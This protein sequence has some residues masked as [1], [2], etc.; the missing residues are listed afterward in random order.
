MLSASRHLRRYLVLLLAPLLL[1]AGC[2]KLDMATEIKDEDHI[3][4]KVTVG[5]SKSMAE[6]SGQDLTSEFSDC[7]QLAKSSGGASNAKVEKFEDDKYIGCTF[8]ADGTAADFTENSED[9]EITFDKDKVTFK[10]DSGTLSDS[11]GSNNPFGS[12]ESLS[13][14]ML[15]DFKISV[16]FP[17][18]VLSHSGSSKVDGR[19]VTWV[20]PKDMFS[21]EG[22]SATAERDGGVPMWVWIVV[23]VAALA[24]IGVVVAV[25]VKKKKGAKGSQPGNGDP[26]WAMQY[27]GQPQG[28]Q[29]QWNNHPGQPY[30]GNPQGQQPPYPNPGQPQPY[31]NQPQPGQPGQPQPGQSQAQPG[32]PG[33]PQ[34]GQSQAQPGQPQSQ[35]GQ[36]WGH[37]PGNG[38]GAPQPGPNPAQRPPSHPD[39]FWKKP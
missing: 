9:T 34:P 15:T 32:Q 26:S 22:L 17:G 36:P 18:K 25:V 27:P 37:A 1:L 7:G 19:T 31:T 13:A 35:P 29:E 11:G 21:D 23:A 4:V 38:T 8:S 14:S 20:D 2:V 12:G 3:H 33:Q 39:D 30:Q 6:M 10:M 5:V 24:I 28:Q 16:T